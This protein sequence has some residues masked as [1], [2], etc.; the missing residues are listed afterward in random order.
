M[1]F[2]PRGLYFWGLQLICLL[3]SLH[4]A[5]NRCQICQCP[6]WDIYPTLPGWRG[7]SASCLLW[8]LLLPV[9]KLL[10]QVQGAPRLPDPFF[11]FLQNE[12]ALLPQTPAQHCR[13]HPVQRSVLIL[14]H[15]SRKDSGKWQSQVRQ[16]R[17]ASTCSRAMIASLRTIRNGPRR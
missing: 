17:Y 7:A 1:W 11:P 10:S 12:T 16:R 5:W 6:R 14:K 13:R 3:S 8:F 15:R 9:Q 4:A 2:I